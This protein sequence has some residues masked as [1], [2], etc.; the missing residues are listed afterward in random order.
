MY[1]NTVQDLPVEGPPTIAILRLM[2][3]ESKALEVPCS[4]FIVVAGRDNED[5]ETEEDESVGVDI[6]ELY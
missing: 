4:D 2:W 3:E 1:H 5:V 6:P